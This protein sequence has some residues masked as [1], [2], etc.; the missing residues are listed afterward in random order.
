[1][2]NQLFHDCV[3]PG[4]ESGAAMSSFQETPSHGWHIRRPTLIEILLAIAIV[5]VLVALIV[6]ATKWA[7][8]GSLRFPVRVIVFDAR[9]S[10][11]IANADVAIFRAPPLPHPN[12][13]AENRGRFD[14]EE[15][16]LRSDIRRGS[17][18]ADGAAVVE[19]EFRTGATHERPTPYAPLR[20]V[21]VAVRAEGYGAVVVP[22]RHEPQPVET[23]RDQGEFVVPVGL[24]P[25]E[26]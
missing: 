16:A 6:P 4:C 24:F 25:G 12:A 19:Y 23:L 22:V 7:S 2:Y 13:L 1:M 26:E 21:W 17:T 14:P 5:A 8:S 18:G 10:T 15:S 20:W 3:M 9:Q 11:P